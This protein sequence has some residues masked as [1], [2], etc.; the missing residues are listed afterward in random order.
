MILVISGWGVRGFYA[1]GVLKWLEELNYFKKIDSLYWVSVGAIIWAFWLSWF[2]AQKIFE[3]FYNINLFSFYKVQF[4]NISLLKNQAFE[5]IFQKYL[6]DDFNKLDKKFFIWATD[7]K[8]SSFKIFEKWELIKPLLWSMS[9]PAIFPPVEYK[10][11][12]LV[13]WGVINNFPVKIAKEKHNKKIIWIALNKVSHSSV[14]KN[15]FEI[16]WKSWDITLESSTLENLNGADFLFYPSLELKI[17]DFRKN[18]MKKSYQIWYNDC[19]KKF[20]N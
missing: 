17:L 19:I 18:L 15:I 3:I 10:D 9:I 13:D 8:T 2:D 7:I 11:F 4:P 6:Y 16:I 5:N 12:Y 20:L 1:L 14:P